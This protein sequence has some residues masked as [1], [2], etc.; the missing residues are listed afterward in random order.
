MIGD[1]VGVPPAQR[2]EPGVESGWCNRDRS[3]PDVEPEDAVE[4]ACDSVRLDVT[5]KQLLQRV[6]VSGYVDVRDLTARVHPGVRATGDRDQRR[7][8]Q[9]QHR[10]ERRLKDA[11]HRS[12]AWLT[13]PAEEGGAVVTEV[14]SQAHEPNEPG[15][16]VIGMA[17][18]VDVVRAVVDCSGVVLGGLL[19]SLGGLVGDLFEGQGIAG[20]LGRRVVADLPS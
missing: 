4:S 14:D 10:R 11:L 7:R 20:D 18:L 13:G 16:P 17:G 5:G 3:H 19:G 12:Q 2:R 6:G 15:H 9:A 1:S 8:R